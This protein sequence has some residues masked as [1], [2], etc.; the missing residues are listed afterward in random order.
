MS[1][2]RAAFLFGCDMEM[3]VEFNGFEAMIDRM[4]TVGD[5]VA[6]RAAVA[7]VRAGLEVIAE[8]MIERAPILDKRTVNSTALEPGAIK[9]D[10]RAFPVRADMD[11]FVSGMAGPSEDTQHVAEWV[12]YGHRVVKGGQSKI[13]AD[14][15]TKGSGHQVRGADG[16]L[17]EVPEHPFLRPAFESSAD[18]SL[19]ACAAA[20]AEVILKELGR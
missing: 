7:G 14:G 9:E 3:D 1:R 2:L 10:I 17:L 6:R 16:E 19:E 11:G 4:A 8:A 13:L 20:G 12:E 5:A 15:R 18:K